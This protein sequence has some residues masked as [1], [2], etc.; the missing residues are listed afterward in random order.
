MLAAARRPLSFPRT[1]AIVIAIIATTMGT[2]VMPTV[3]VLLT[4][5]DGRRMT[6]ATTTSAILSRLVDVLCCPSR[7]PQAGGSRGRADNHGECPVPN[8]TGLL[9]ELNSGPLAPEARIMPL[10]QAAK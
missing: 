9:R 5:M 4:I 8:P 7:A 3:I 2:A 1:L 10:D 6:F